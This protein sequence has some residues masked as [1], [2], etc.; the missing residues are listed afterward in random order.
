MAET[1]DVRSVWFAHRVPLASLFC[2]T[3]SAVFVIRVPH[4][5]SPRRRPFK[6]GRVP[7]HTWAYR[8]RLRQRDYLR[9][10]DCLNLVAA[11]LMGTLAAFTYSEHPQLTTILGLLYAGTVVWIFFCT[12][13]RRRARDQIQAEVLWGLFSQINKEIFD[14]DHRTRVTLF[15]PDS[16][17]RDYITPWYRYSKGGR[18]PIEEAALSKARYKRGEG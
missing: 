11:L 10:D 6:A 16:I 2:D 12:V 1:L 4:I 14:G 5:A 18:G 8:L 17:R 7:F 9:A 3:I 13:R 15:R